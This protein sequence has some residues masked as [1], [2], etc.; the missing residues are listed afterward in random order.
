MGVCGVLDQ[1]AAHHPVNAPQV[2]RPRT[3]VVIAKLVTTLA[4]S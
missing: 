1:S 2:D 3:S 4:S